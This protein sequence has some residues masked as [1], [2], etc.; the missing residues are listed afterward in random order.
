MDYENNINGNIS[1]EISIKG[2]VQSD[3]KI[4]VRGTICP[5]ASIQGKIFPEISVQ[6]NVVSAVTLRGSVQKGSGFYSNGNVNVIMKTKEEWAALPTYE[7]IKGYIYVYTNWYIEVNQETGEEKWIPRIKIGNGVNYVEDLQFEGYP[8]IILNSLLTMMNV[9]GIDTGITYNQGTLIETILRDMLCPTLYPKLI[10]P[11]LSLIPSSPLLLE[12]GTSKM[13]TI[14]ANFNRGS[15]NPAYGT[16]GYRSG[17][18]QTYKIN[19]GNVQDTNVFTVALDQVHNT[20]VGTVTYAEGEQPKDSS[21]NNYSTPLSAGS[22]NS[23]ILTYEFVNAIWANE[24][25]AETITK[26]ELVSYFAKQKIFVF[27][28]CSIANPEVFDVPSSWNIN[29][30]EV[31]NDLNNLYEDCAVEFTLSDVEH[32]NAGGN[33]IAYTRYT[34]NLGY[35]MASR[36]IRIKWS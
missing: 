9:G 31:K 24:E 19:D 22:I 15:I 5:E 21:G 28:N 1:P 4:N 23:P 34:C 18:A 20:F 27:P 32:S 14:T 7:S 11:S 6:G 2:T 12:K 29:A 13:E 10:N 26:C 35:D 33:T 8:P 17:E 25:N 36:T 3:N 30:V 16:S